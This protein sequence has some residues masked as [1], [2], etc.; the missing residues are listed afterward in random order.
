MT[1][2]PRTLVALSGGV[3]SSVAAALV[4]AEGGPVEAVTLQ[5]V[6]CQDATGVRACCGAEGLAAARRVARHLGMA[7]R[8]WDVRDEFRERVLRPAWDEYARGRTP[9]PCLW[10]NSRIKFG[11]LLERARAEGFDRVASGHHARLVEGP[12]GPLVARGAD[13]EKDQSY[14][15]AGVAPATLAGLVFPVGGMT[16][17]EVRAEA[18]R[19]ALPTA[20]RRESSDACFRLPGDE[21]FAESL[22]RLFE[23]PARSGLVLDTA[24]VVV[25]RH[26]GL[27]GFTRGQ[28]RGLGLGGGVRRWVLGLD[29]GSGAL[30]VTTD[31]SDLDASAFLAAGYE[32]HDPE[33]EPTGAAGGVVRALVQT[34]YRERPVPCLVRG[35][36]EGRVLVELERPVRAV[37]P[38]QAAAFYRGDAVVAVAWIEECAKPPSGG[39]A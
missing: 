22:R 27:H 12:A 24:G 36:G 7:H 15:L 11:L 13:P 39:F 20:E 19:L 32:A 16:K 10:C 35:A 18:R 34:R 23:A 21:C 8:V 37:T 25:G 9:S 28:R 30:T 29:A 2:L 33:A 17:D 38:G 31:E 5:V 3:D 14:F 1:P 4:Q 26:G 6:P